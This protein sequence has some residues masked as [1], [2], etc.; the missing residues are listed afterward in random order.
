MKNFLDL[1]HFENKKLM[2]KNYVR[3][4]L[5]AIVLITILLNLSPLLQKSQVAYL[6]ENNQVVLEEVTYYQKVQ[7]ERKFAEQYNGKPLTNEICNDVKTLNAAYNRET[8]LDDGGY[9]PLLNTLLPYRSL[10]ELGINPDNEMSNLADQAYDLMLAE[11]ENRC[12]ENAEEFWAQKRNNMEIPL[13]MYYAQGYY[14]I[15]K[16]L[17]W[18]LVMGLCFVVFCLCSVF[19]N[20]NAYR[21]DSLIRTTLLG[22]S[23]TSLAKLVTGEAIAISVIAVLSGITVIIQFAIH[24][25]SGAQAP[26]QLLKNIGQNQ[27]A[28]RSGTLTAG[29]AVIMVVLIGLLLALFLGAATMMLSKVFNATVPALVLPISIMLL[30]LLISDDAGLYSIYE[31]RNQIM[32]FFPLQRMDVE[33]IILDERLVTL[34]GSQLT[35]TQMSILLYGGMAAFLLLGCLVICKATVKSKK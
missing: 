18:P 6:D 4:A 24:G 14:S 34:V 16:T 21:T 1:C 15:L 7:L 29:N 11:Q 22:T 26:V 33:G 28:Y 20:E 8:S 5:L 30:S 2:Q 9:I 25:V 27:F 10:I 31:P 12:P 35:A 19:S 23:K 17:Y 32:S 13:T 3:I